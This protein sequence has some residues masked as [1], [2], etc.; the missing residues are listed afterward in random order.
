V[1]LICWENSWAATFLGALEG[2]GAE[3]IDQ[4]RIPRDLVLSAI[5][6]RQD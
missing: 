1:A 4:T 6:A 2:S 5:A 3:L